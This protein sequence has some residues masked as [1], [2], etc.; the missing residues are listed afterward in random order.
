[1]LKL[2]KITFENTPRIP[3]LRTGPLTELDCDNPPT[4]LKDW[5]ILV[6]PQAIVL[7]SPPGWT[8]SS[9][10][11]AERDPKGPIVMHEIPRAGAYLHWTGDEADIEAVAKA[12]KY[13]TGVLG[14]VKPAPIAPER[15][16]LSQ[17]PPGQMG[18]A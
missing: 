14:A 12:G 16:I 15:S 10:R 4:P 6:R 1:M 7:V 11:P 5:R 13:D 3:G 2:T 18:D 8:T 9:Q 17:V